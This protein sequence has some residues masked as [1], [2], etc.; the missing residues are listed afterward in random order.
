MVKILILNFLRVYVVCFGIGFSELYAQEIVEY[1][2]NDSLKTRGDLLNGER[3]GYWEER[4]ANGRLKSEGFY[5]N[6]ILQDLWVYNCE[7]GYPEREV[8]WKDGKCYQIATYFSFG[9]PYIY[10]DFPDGISQES[11]LDYLKIFQWGRLNQLRL[12]SD[13]NIDQE[14]I[15]YQFTAYSLPKQHQFM[16]G[17]N[18]NLQN[19]YLDSMDIVEKM[20]NEYL[21]A[22]CKSLGQKFEYTKEYVRGRSDRLI[23]NL[24][25]GTYLE[26]H[27]QFYKTEPYHTYSERVYINDTLINKT[28]YYLEGKNVQTCTD[29]HTNGKQE[30]VGRYEYGKKE[31]TWKYYS[32]EGKVVRKEN[33][34]NDELRKSKSY[35]D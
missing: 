7:H 34:K 4:Y 2:E 19:N 22:F 18:N 31:G 21:I 10:L 14:N 15:H 30:A 27:S 5:T 25:D 29:Y 13:K 26:V 11:Y 20:R 28:E 16:F 23:K 6:G 33:Y 8:K 17:I 1:W 3:N 9:F 12:L 32:R 24:E 35:S